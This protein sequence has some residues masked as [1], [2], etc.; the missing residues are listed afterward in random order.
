MINK[1]LSEVLSHP[2]DGVVAIVTQGTD[3]PHVVNTWNSYVHISADD[4]LLIPAGFMHRTEKNIA[5]NDKIQLTMGSR[6]VQG[7]MYKGTGFLIKG[8]A[9]FLKDGE[10]FTMMKKQYDWIRAVLEITIEHAIQTI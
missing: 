9:R 7:K 2:A 8:T 1:T 3:E 4:K 6:E 10:E 5:S